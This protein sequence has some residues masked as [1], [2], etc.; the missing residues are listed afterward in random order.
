MCVYVLCVCVCLWSPEYYV[1]D[2]LGAE[3]IGGCEFP[4]IGAR[5]QVLLP[6]VCIL[7]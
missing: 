7:N 2:P 3:G 5:S 6:T 1:S 4:D